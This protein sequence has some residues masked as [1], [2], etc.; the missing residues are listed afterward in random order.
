MNCMACNYPMEI[1]SEYEKGSQIEVTWR[2]PI[3]GQYTIS[4]ERNWSYE[5]DEEED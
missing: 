1:A 5:D 2:C 4:L 3:C